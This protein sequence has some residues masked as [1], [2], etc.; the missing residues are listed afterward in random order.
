[1]TK[2]KLIYQGDLHIECTH[3]SGAKITTDAPKDNMGKGELFSPTDL[4]ALSLGTCMLTLM[5]IAAKKLGI[6]LKGMS[7]E[8]EKEMTMAPVR[9]IGKI[10]VRIRSSVTPNQ[11]AREKMEK[12]ALDCPVRHSLHPDIKL[13]A[14]FVWGL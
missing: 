1:M 10:I 3:E 14:D 2:M 8:V 12:A 4:F 9:R 13:E 11:M 5:G 7:C 6:D